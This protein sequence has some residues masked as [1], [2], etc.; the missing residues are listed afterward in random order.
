MPASPMLET[1]LTAPGWWEILRGV[2]VVRGPPEEPA[3]VTVTPTGKG[4]T[5]TYTGVGPF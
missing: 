2:V 3:G 1:S 4:V 5:R